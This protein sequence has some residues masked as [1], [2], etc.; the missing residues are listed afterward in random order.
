ML[1]A[2]F[3]HVGETDQVAVDVGA[4]VAQRIAHTGLRGEVGDGIEALRREQGLHRCS[5]GQIALDEA[6]SL[7]A[8]ELGDACALQAGVVVIV[9]VVEADD[10]VA[11]LEQALGEVVADETGGAG[12]EKGA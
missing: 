7:M 4:W 2:A 11:R 5:I 6:E 3:E 10:D 1:A 8:C 12:D 9:E